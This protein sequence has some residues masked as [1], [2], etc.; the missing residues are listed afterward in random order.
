MRAGRRLG[1]GLVIG[2]VVVAVSPCA[3]WAHAYLLHTSPLASAQINRAPTQ[4]ALTFNEAVEPRFM[5]VSVT[6]AGGHPQ[7]SGAPQRAPTD[8]NTIVTPLRH[9]SE[10][11]YL[12]YWRAISADGHP[13]RG[14]FT[15]AVGPN[16]GPPPQFV[17]PSLTESATTAPLLTLRW[18]SFLAIMTAVGL[19]LLRTVIARP[20]VS[21]VPGTS[22]S[23]ISLAF[24]IAIALALF[25]VPIYIELATA[26]FAF[27]SVVD[28]AGV[29]PLWRSSAFGRSW[30]D[31]ELVLLTF[32]G[33]SAIAIAADRAE[34]RQRTVSALLSLYAAIAAAAALLLVPALAGHAAQ[35]S[36]RGL[37]IVLDWLHLV[38]GSVWLGGLIG[39]LVLWWSLGS[40]HRVS[41]LALCVPR[42]SR[43]AFVSVLV[44]IGSGIGASLVHFPTFGSFVHTS[45]GQALIAKIALL[46]TA[47]V[48]AAGN[49]LRTRP[50][51]QASGGDAEIGAQPARM[52][53]VLVSGEVLLVAGA[54]FAASILTSLPPPP[55][56]LASVG[57][58]S[59]HVGPGPVVR[60]VNHGPYRLTFHIDPNK[61]VVPNSFAVTITKNGRPVHGADVTANFSM[62]D[63]EMPQLAYN[64]AER[65]P[66][67][68][69]RAVNALVMVGHWG[70]T[71]EV[72]P[73]GAAPFQVVLVDHAAG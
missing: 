61:A 17:I 15:F 24:G 36:P 34:L 3:A 5:I 71:F 47:M 68:F 20:L 11:W 54:L 27:K 62:L 63:M 26:K 55:K 35:T 72:R 23:S 67:V 29:V 19:F 33:A 50:A 42:F 69:S 59:A 2:L 28:V 18:L 10:G 66:G 25:T 37:S 39:L 31:L 32:A 7:T 65:R 16:A 52:L 45:Y 1:L 21:R 70:L 53:R 57:S 8:G 22:L 60:V 64:L 4:L 12:V 41:G 40:A 38:S 43:V 48:L 49:L 73:P 56:A 44:L 14:A 6:D 58:P 9:V 51:L 30:V 46:L 13:V